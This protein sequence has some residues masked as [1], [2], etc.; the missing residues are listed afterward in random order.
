MRG[1][2]RLLTLLLLAV[3]VAALV[4]FGLA[5]SHSAQLGRRAPSLPKEAL[6]GHPLTLPGLLAG[7]HGRPAAVVFFASWCDPCHQ[8]A[9]ALER[10]SQ[11]P[12]GKGRIVAVDWSDGLSGARAFIRHYHWTF[13]VLRDGEGLVGNAYRFPGL[14]ATFVVDGNG[15]IGALLLGPQTQSSLRRALASGAA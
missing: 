3:A 11:S 12:A 4:K 15:H 13:P 14:P 8:E 9:A 6:V 2:S 7:A 10:F 1:R 5:S